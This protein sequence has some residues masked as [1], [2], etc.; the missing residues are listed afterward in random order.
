MVADT[1]SGDDKA[2]SSMAVSP[3]Y[4]DITTVLIIVILG[5]DILAS[6]KEATIKMFLIIKNLR[7][8]FALERK[9]ITILPI[10]HTRNPRYIIYISEA[11]YADSSAPEL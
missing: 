11:I 5:R 2:Y 6:T 1:K 10:I 4:L 9:L 8:T 7:L 3:I